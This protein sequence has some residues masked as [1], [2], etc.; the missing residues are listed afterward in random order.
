MR[1]LWVALATA[2]A[3]TAGAGAAAILFQP[4]QVLDVTVLG[5][6]DPTASDRITEISVEVSNP[7]PLDVVPIFSVPGGALRNWYRWYAVEGPDR[8]G[9][10]ETARFVIVQEPYTGVPVTEAVQVIVGDLN[11][12]RVRGASDV[13][14]PVLERPP[15]AV[16]NPAFV[17]W[18]HSMFF[19][20][21]L[22][23]AWVPWLELY[24]DDT[25]FV[26]GADGRL[27]LHLDLDTSRQAADDGA[28]RFPFGLEANRTSGY[29]WSLLSLRQRIDFPSTL[30]IE[31]DDGDRGTFSGGARTEVGVLLEDVHGGTQLMILFADPAT[32]ADQQ[33]RLNLTFEDYVA[34]RILVTNRTVELDLV[35][36]WEELGWHVPAK[37]AVPSLLPYG[38]GDVG[39]GA[40]SVETAAERMEVVRPVELKVFVA[41]YPPHERESLDAT[42]TFVGGP[43][44]DPAPSRL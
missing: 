28:L 24:G 36:L 30:R 38:P 19:G 8:L 25:A 43:A 22:P 6:A 12:P 14:R 2:A 10:G 5:A 31:F 34:H 3:V 27:H 33:A 9:A 44:W 13:V 35:A 37:R 26:D 1:P 17:S 18:E 42:F 32:D 4:P 39:M 23:Y 41:S 7:G 11:E 40:A 15:P 16:L 21:P 29:D 20:S